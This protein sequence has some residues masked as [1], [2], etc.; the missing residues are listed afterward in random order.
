MMYKAKFDTTI[1]GIPAQIGVVH[2]MKAPATYRGHS[3]LDYWGYT[4]CDW[5]VLDRKGYKADWLSKK[6][7]QTEINRIE[8]EIEVMCG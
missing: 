7:S 4:E 1:A 2:Y 5:E 3:D 6:L 8:N